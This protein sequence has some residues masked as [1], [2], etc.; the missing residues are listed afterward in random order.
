[1]TKNIENVL[2]NVKISHN[3]ALKNVA[4]PNRL[5][6]VY[7]LIVW[8]N[9]KRNKNRTDSCFVLNP[10]LTATQFN[11]LFFQ[12]Y[13]T[14]QFI[15]YCSINALFMLRI[16]VGVLV[17]EILIQFSIDCIDAYKNFRISVSSAVR[18][19]DISHACNLYEIFTL[20]LQLRLIEVDFCN[21]KKQRANTFA[22]GNLQ[23][24]KNHIIRA[25]K[26]RQLK[27]TLL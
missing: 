22:N 23:W 13:E 8:S 12:N 2:T 25:E 9:N 14:V 18:S 5:P 15:L 6:I 17:T 21:L 11:T 4:K 16:K 1:M 24:K 10:N 7:R 26:S 19:F 3:K 20:P 27:F